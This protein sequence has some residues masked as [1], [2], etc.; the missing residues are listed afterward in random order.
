MTN[1]NKVKTVI[2]PK[3]LEFV[4]EKLYQLVLDNFIYPMVGKK[5]TFGDDLKRAGV[6][7]FGKKFAG[8]FPS[9]MIPRLTKQQPYAILNLDSSN[10]PG[11]HWIAVAFEKDKIWVY[12][13]FGRPTR[14]IIPSL[15]DEYGI[16]NL[17]MVDD[18]AE[19]HI[20]EDDCGARCLAWLYIFD[21]YGSR[22]AR[23][24]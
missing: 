2:V 21:R 12:D 5:V 20:S 3:D 24:I 19:Q 11:S 23:L 6:K 22:I 8:I 17:L 4:A 10:E 13:S 16:E 1:L 14:E 18:D 9:D 15:I 7:L